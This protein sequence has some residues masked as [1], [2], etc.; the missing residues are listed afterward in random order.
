MLRIAPFLLLATLLLAGC[1][2]T[3]NWREARLGAGELKALLP[4]KPDQGSRRLD[5]AGQEVE[6]RMLGCEAGGALFVL[7]QA[8]LRAPEQ[9][10]AAQV[11]WQAAMLGN[12]QAGNSSTAPYAQPGADSR[13]PPVRLNAQG[14]RPDGSA[15]TA[16]GVWFA[17][18]S[19]LYHA[20]IY[21]DKIVPEMS[22]PFFAG[23]ELQ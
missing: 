22:E 11:Q 19:Q 23:L 3:L 18:G 6:I 8:D 20:V 1:N 14:W 17:R 10:M 2:P 4:C 13:P 21:A 12:M 9:V 7:A 15:V 5:L 16:Q